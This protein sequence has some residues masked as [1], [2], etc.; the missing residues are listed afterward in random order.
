MYKTKLQEL[1]QQKQWGFP[2]YTC[3][4]DGQDHHPRFNASVFGSRS[5]ASPFKAAVAVG[6]RVF[7]SPKQ[8]CFDS[9]KEAEDA[10][11]EAACLALLLESFQQNEYGHYKNLL[12]ELTQREGFSMPVY[13]TT[14]SGEPHRPVFLSTVDVD[15]EIFCG[16]GAKS[17]KQAELEAARVACIALT[18]PGSAKTGTINGGERSYLLCNK[19]RVYPMFPEQAF[20][21]GITVLPISD[22]KWVA[23]SLEFPNEQSN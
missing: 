6:G 17:K 7:E 3:M 18:E 23:I 13:T 14:K 11:A 16:K 2:K 12:Q 9:F 4:K 10:A 8:E 22:D 15:G 1:C 19:V 20:P 5:H 21:E